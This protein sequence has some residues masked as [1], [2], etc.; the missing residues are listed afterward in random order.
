MSFLET[1]FPCAIAQGSTAGPER[2]TEVVMLGSGH[3]ERNARWADSRRMYNA[4]YGVKGLNDLHS[5]IEFFEQVRGKLYGFRWKD[6]TDFKSCPP[7]NGVTAFD[8]SIGAGNGSD[9]SFQLHKKYGS[10]A[11]PWYRTITK[12]VQGTVRMSVNGAVKLEGTHFSVS[13][14]T[15]IVTFLVGSTPAAGH[16]IT[17]GYEFDVP[18]RFD[19]DR[20]EINISN[21]KHGTIPNIPI[22]ELR[23]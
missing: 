14:K 1:Q 6:F 22:I 21:F 11:T 2:K 12:P 19:T 4:G 10:G 16:L 20:M 13:Y 17:A 7:E 18:A 3:E 9:T 23:V 8:Q 5:V 15:G